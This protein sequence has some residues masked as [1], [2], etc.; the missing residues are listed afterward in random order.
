MT[1]RQANE[2]RNWKGIIF[3]YDTFIP[4]DSPECQ[5]CLTDKQAT[6]LRG[7]LEPVGWVTRW[8]SDTTDI[9]QDAIEAFR[10]DTIR[11]LM[12]SCCNEE[13]A[14]IFR[15]T[16]D[17]VLQ[18]SNDGGTTWEDNPTEDP[19]HSS[20]TY[21][22]VPGEPSDDKKCIA[23]TG[24]T[25]IIKGQVGDQLTD[26]MSHFTLQELIETWVNT[27]L[28]TSNPF[29]ALI[30]IAVNQIFALVISAL[31]AA[32]TSGV[33]D[34]LTC[35]FFCNIADDLSFD[36]SRW[37]TVRSDITD[38]ISG[39]AGLFFEHLVFLMGAV[40]LTNLAR[41]QA[42]TTGD[43]SGCSCGACNLSTWDFYDGSAG[44]TVSKTDTE[45]VID[46]NIRG[47][48]HY[49]V[50]IIGASSSDCQTIHNTTATGLEG[51]AYT[52]CGEN[53]TDVVI[54]LHSSVGGVGDGE[55]TALLLK[56]STTFT[57]T[58]TCA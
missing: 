48:G 18:S 15:W 2:R 35:I 7:L 22:P 50:I 43:C 38:Q 27:L 23:A 19:R 56:G 14:I 16:E 31:R 29:L 52:L 49:Y 37:A 25:A 12:M 10:D 28:Q 42:A 21:P 34:T 6:L 32:L 39:I 45:W 40:G 44:T 20:P 1:E 46:A 30:N 3:P 26:D 33:Y 51:G 9:D 11:R 54:P 24:M 53:P 57:L 17:G 58:V 8:W 36:D 5:Y 55:Y 47:D 41:S 13:F 4:D